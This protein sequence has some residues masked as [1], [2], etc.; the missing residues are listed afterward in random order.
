MTWLALAQPLGRVDVA[1]GT[2]VALQAT[3]LRTPADPKANPTQRLLVWRVYRVAGRYVASDAQAIL[4]L[5]L[6]RLAGRGDDSAVLMFYT[7]LAED[8]QGAERL[9]NFVAEHLNRIA[10]ALEPAAR[11]ATVQR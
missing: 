6:Q 2:T 1:A 3:Q 4:W 9:Q 11:A 8:G 10:A 7:R 5:A